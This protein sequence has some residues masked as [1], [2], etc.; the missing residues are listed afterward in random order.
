VAQLDWTAVEDAGRRL[1][2]TT[3]RE[4]FDADPDRGRRLV[5]RAGDWTVDWSKDRLDEPALQALQDLARSAGVEDGIAAMFRGDRINVTEDRPVLHVALRRPADEPIEVDGRDV[6][7]EVHE[8][9]GRMRA[10]STRVL[11]GDWTGTTG[12][13]I[14]TVVNIGIG[15]SDLGPRMV[16]RALRRYRDARLDVRFVANVDGAELEAALAGVDAASALF[17]VCSKTFTTAETLANARAARQWLTERLPDAD[18]AKHFVAVSTNADAVGEFGIDTSSMFGFWDWVGGRYSLTSAVGLSI[19][20]AVGPDHFDALLA[21]FHDVD[22]HVRTTPLEDNVAVLLALI[23]I[24]DRDVL[25]LTDLVV[26][27]YAQDLE[28]LPAYLQQLDMESNGK[29]VRLDGTPVDRPT[30]PVVWGQ[31]GTN[32][33]HAFYQ[34]LHQGTTVVPAD[35]IGFLQ[36]L[37]GLA[38][39]HD[40]LTANLL[41]QSQALAFGRTLDEVLAAGVDPAV[42]PHR[43]FPGDRPTTTWLAPELTPRTLGQLIALYEHK[44]LVQGLVWGI[45]SFDQWGVELGKTLAKQLLPALRGQGG[46]TGALDSSTAHLVE[47]YRAAADGR[48]ASD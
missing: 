2:R 11:S 47:L 21:G 37:S 34:L 41:A 16:T 7:A 42:A 32:G 9:L 10:F 19:M 40:E 22:E 46:D 12:E 45:D 26:L 31:P 43:V 27:P 15:G 8:V 25:G 20:L 30:G 4:L 13:R 14:R 36:P 5:A 6:V 28:L 17:V 1:E 35:M 33:Q 38:E 44:V 24:W 23:G 18:V 39:Q 29:R 48:A 3:L